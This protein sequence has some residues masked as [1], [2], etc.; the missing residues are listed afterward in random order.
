MA[1]GYTPQTWV[2]GSAP[3]LSAANLQT[4]DNG[5]NAA[6]DAVDTLI[7]NDGTNNPGASTGAKIV[8]ALTKAGYSLSPATGSDNL[9]NIADGSTYKRVAAAV[10]TA[11]NADTY[12]ANDAD[13]VSAFGI[14]IS[15]VPVTTAET[16]DTMCTGGLYRVDSPTGLPAGA[17]AVLVI[18]VSALYAKQFASSYVRKN[19]YIRNIENGVAGSWYEIWNASSDGNG[20]RPPAPKPQTGT[21]EAGLWGGTSGYTTPA[22]SG[23]YAVIAF[24]SGA[25]YGAVPAATPSA[26]MNTWFGTT[27]ITGIVYWRVT[28]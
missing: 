5:I 23:T 2:N 20:G 9:D 16:L 19:L 21:T 7:I 26:D 11:L 13:K 4:M 25:F 27:G 15:A 18:P 3:A 12:T 17:H 6:C 14:G 24:K 8:S 22:Y 10:A 28:V 1:I